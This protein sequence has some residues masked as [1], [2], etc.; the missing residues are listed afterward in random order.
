MIRL[1]LL[2]IGLMLFVGC[3]ADVSQDM[4]VGSESPGGEVSEEANGKDST[5]VDSGQ[6]ST[7]AVCDP[8]LNI[9]HRGASGYAPEHTIASYQL[10]QEK[11]GDFIE[12]D[13]QITE[14]GTLVAMHD[15]DVAR[16]TSSAGLVSDF[17]FEEVKELDVGSWFNVENP[18]I[19]QPAFASLRIP[20]LNEI[21][22]NFGTDANYYIETKDPEENPQ[23]VEALID[24]LNA[25]DLI[26]S[27]AKGKVIIQSFSAD[28]LKEVKKLAPSIPLVQL[29]STQG[30][31][32][33]SDEKLKQIKEYA[34]GI[35]PKYDSLTE[36]F[37]EQVRNAGLEIHPYTVNNKEDMKKLIQWGV[38]G[39][40]TNYPD[41]L[42]EVIDE[43]GCK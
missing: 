5:V 16:T 20:S 17:T 34:Y 19:A 42:A 1:I 40:F 24:T 13:L 3:S 30:S 15:A 7:T 28:S 43:M 37:V 27:D 31:L 12:I 35:G 38:T 22:E 8:V 11:G 25:Y 2:G 36:K 29:I 14:D 4:D 41:K 23:M 21:I 10:G 18:N 9:S 32:I 39:M 6:E 26:G 33:M